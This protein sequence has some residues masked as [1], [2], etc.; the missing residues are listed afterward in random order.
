ML[1]RCILVLLLPFPVSA[2][3]PQLAPQDIRYTRELMARNHLIAHV[4]LEMEKDK[5]VRYRYDRYPEVKRITIAGSSFAELNA[6]SWLESKDWGETGSPVNQAKAAELNTY[7]TVAELPFA[8][9]E[10]HDKRQ[11][12]VVWKLIKR[13]PEKDYQFYT[14]EESRAVPRPDGVYPRFK[15]IKYKDSSDGELLLEHF[16]GQLRASDKM[17]PVEIGYESLI[18]LPRNTVI[19]IMPSSKSAA[20][21]RER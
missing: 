9:T 4:E 19:K 14:Y 10:Q 7:A 1:K 3:N 15:F 18:L 5:Y 8:P 2:Q 17:I 12:A 11:G 16:S 20:G 13:V 21:G 6:K